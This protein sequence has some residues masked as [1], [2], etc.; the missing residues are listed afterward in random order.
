M[1]NRE[2]RRERLLWLGFAL[3]M[4]APS[5]SYLVFSKEEFENKFPERAKNLKKWSRQF[6]IYNKLTDYFLRGEK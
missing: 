5:C 6:E 1:Q 3:S 2:L 4:S